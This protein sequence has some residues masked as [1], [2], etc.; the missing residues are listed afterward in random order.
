MKTLEE[1]A[2]ATPD[3][4]LRLVII[5]Y[6]SVPNVSKGDMNE[7]EEV[8]KKDGAD[9]TPLAFVKQSGIIIYF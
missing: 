1:V 4:K 8:L 2:E 9:I 3:D 7:L 5:F 6:L